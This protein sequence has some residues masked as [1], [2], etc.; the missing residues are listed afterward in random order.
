MDVN[1]IVRHCYIFACS[2]Y[3][4]AYHDIGWLSLIR[5]FRVE[6]GEWR[7]SMHNGTIAHGFL[8]HMHM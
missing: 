7:V 4:I 2:L 8:E 1:F 3:H 5:H 6:G